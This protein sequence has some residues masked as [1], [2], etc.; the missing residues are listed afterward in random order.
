MSCKLRCYFQS[1]HTEVIFSGKELPSSRF[2]VRRSHGTGILILSLLSTQSLPQGK[3]MKKLP[4][5]DVLLP[6]DV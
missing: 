3:R 6:I 5:S 2:L 4:L 1:Q